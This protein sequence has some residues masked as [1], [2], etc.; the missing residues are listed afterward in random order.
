MNLTSALKTALNELRRNAPR[1]M[2]T[3]LGI[4]I[5]VGAVIAMMEIGNGAAVAIERTIAAMGANMLAI[6]PRS[7]SAAGGDGIGD[8]K[9]LTPEDAQALGEEVSAVAAVAPIIRGRTKLVYGNRSWVPTYLFGTTPSYLEVR[10]WSPLAEGEAFTDFDVRNSN[11]VCLVGQTLVRE[12]FGGQSPVGREVRVRNVVFKVTGVL[13]KKGANM[14]GRDQDD[15]LLAPWT[16]VKYRVIGS[17]SDSGDGEGNGDGGQAPSGFY[18]PSPQSFYPVRSVK[19]MANTPLPVRFTNVD[20]ILIA[21]RSKRLVPAAERQITLLLRER[22]N[23]RPKDPDDF[24][25]RDMTEVNA[26]M[27]ATTEMMADL[28]LSVAMISLM[29]GGVGIMNIMLVS[30]TE[31]TREIGLRMAVGAAP[32]D[33]LRQFLIEAVVLCLLGGAIGIALG[34]G[35]SQIISSVL[36]WPMATSLGAIMAAVGVSVGVGLIFGFYPAWKASRLNPID[37]L[38]HE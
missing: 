36:R 34:R 35:S 6:S 8:V 3:M 14:S 18:P 7:G 21:A 29:V 12:L 26:A 30:V 27:S 22:H 1:T 17:S 2:L 15:I 31:R 28:L 11:K 32:G 38:R 33:I 19:Q 23:L 13:Q 16:T 37:A 10:Q 9:T 25:I 20:Q 5:G 4:V 24:R